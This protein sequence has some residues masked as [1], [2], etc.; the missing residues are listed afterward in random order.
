MRLEYDAAT[1]GFRVPVHMAI[2]PDRLS[3]VNGVQRE[4]MR[5]VLDDLL[6]HGMHAELQTSSYLTGAMVVELTTPAGAKPGAVQMENDE[7]LIPG[8]VG[9]I[10]G[11]VDS[12]S[13]IAQKLD[14]IPFD[15]IGNN[16]NDTLASVH[17]L[18]ASPDVRN[19]VRDL[20]AT[21]GN[22][23]DLVRKTD[24][25]V[26]P[27]LKQL[28][29]LESQ[30]GTHAATCQRF[31]GFG[32]LWRRQHVPP[33]CVPVDG[34]GQRNIAGGARFGGLP[35]PPSGSADPWPRRG[36]EKPMRPIRALM[37]MMVLA[38]CSSAE[39]T[40]YTLAAHPAR[41]KPARHA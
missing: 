28:P 21:L 9:G 26:T 17:Q 18:V 23:R 3:F 16:L 20:S 39:P 38:G 14:K 32:R 31:V 22:V 2:E 36:G 30:S 24:A 12:L 1:G 25:G 13:A 4:D 19:A 34:S 29:Q 8:Q 6:R 37:L 11:I 5:G 41:R 35:R 40:Y 15:Q 10:G 7:L 33:G 27:V